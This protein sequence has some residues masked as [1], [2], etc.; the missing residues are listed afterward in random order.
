MNA[1]VQKV[2]THMSGTNQEEQNY[3]LRIARGLL[4]LGI[5]LLVAGLALAVSAVSFAGSAGAEPRR[6]GGPVQV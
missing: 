5:S 1:A 2:M 3:R 4:A 6:G